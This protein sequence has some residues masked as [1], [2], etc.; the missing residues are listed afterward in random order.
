[1]L[2]PSNPALE[3]FIR[4]IP[5][6]SLVAPEDTMEILRLLQ[7]V[8]L[9]PG[10]VLFREGAP[11]DAMWVLGTGCEV[12]ISATPPGSKR[13]VVVAYARGGGTLGE[14]ALIDDGSRSGTAVVMQ[15]GPAQRIQASDFHALRSAYTPAAYKVMRRMCMDLCARLRATNDRI[16]PS[17]GSNVQAPELVPGKRPPVER[18]DEFGPFKPLPKV[19]KL[20]LAQ[21]L[22]LV[23]VTEMTPIFAEGEVADAAYFILAGEV[24]IGRGGRT[25]A[26]LGPGSM[27]GLVAA[28]DQGTRSA[29]AITAGPAALLRLNDSDFDGLFSSGHRFAYQ[30]I[31]LVARQLVSH[32]R[33]A[34][35]LLPAPGQAPS[36]QPG[37]ASP[38]AAQRAPEPEM[39]MLPLDLDLEVD[40]DIDV[41]D[42]LVSLEGEPL[43]S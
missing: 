37:A 7:P 3:Q 6:F 2:P 8:Q 10:E 15:G 11:G 34:N 18:L 29:S 40:V 39:G 26:N 43:S 28:I 33:N 16:A 38:A 4:S 42:V 31:D 13:P 41:Q 25:F 36:P 35:Q 24:S 5:L 23:E 19:V 30:L 32:L 22:Q 20:A 27:F 12:S 9:E 21:K 14:M 1:M 17:G